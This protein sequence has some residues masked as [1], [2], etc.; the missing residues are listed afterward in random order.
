MD[1]KPEVMMEDKWENKTGHPWVL[2][3]G[4]TTNKTKNKAQK[5]LQPIWKPA[6]YYE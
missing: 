3:C 5:R 1:T 4:C 2:Q 6:L